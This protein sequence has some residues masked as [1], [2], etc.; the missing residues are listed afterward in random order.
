MKTLLLIAAALV[1][2]ACARS[3]AK[4]PAEKTRAKAAGA[5]TRLPPKTSPKIKPTA[6]PV[7]ERLKLSDADWK[8]RLTPQ[9]FH[10]LRE[11]GTERPGTGKL[12]KNKDD[13]VYVCAACGAPLFDS[14]TKFESGTGWPSF[15]TPIQEGRVAEHSDDAYGMS[16]VEVRCARCNGHLG[17]VFNDGP[18]PTGQRYCINSLA[19]DFEPVA[20]TKKATP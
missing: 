17:H 7:G 2:G 15:Y 16:R 6:P 1:L 20:A 19:L 11:A 12:L 14:E 4:D 3:S 13:G 9:E 10:I 8:K 5:A 18:K